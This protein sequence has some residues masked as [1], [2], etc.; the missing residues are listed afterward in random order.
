MSSLLHQA[1]RGSTLDSG[2]DLAVLAS[3]EVDGCHGSLEVTPSPL[4]TDFL[5]MYATPPGK[6]CAGVCL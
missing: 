1:C 4:Y 5:I 6:V 2:T 3:D